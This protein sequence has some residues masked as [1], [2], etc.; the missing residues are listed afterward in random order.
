MIAMI[1]E[2][3][4]LNEEGVKV[5]KPKSAPRPKDVAVPDDLSSALAKNTKARATFEKFSPSH[6]REYIEWITGAKQEATRQ[7]RLAQTIE[8]L[9]EGK[10]RNWKYER[11]S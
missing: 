8:W 9:V 7:K 1:R 4:R 6:K 3:V 11:K 10:S 5:Q 2:A